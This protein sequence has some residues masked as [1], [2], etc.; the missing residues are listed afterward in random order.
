MARRRSLTMDGEP[1]GFDAG[2]GM[3]DDG[4]GGEGEGGGNFGFGLDAGLTDE[5]SRDSSGRDPMTRQSVVEGSTDRPRDIFGTRLP[6][7]LTPDPAP[8][9]DGGGGG[10]AGA[11]DINEILGM[12]PQGVE[13]G[14][15]QDTMSAPLQSS[16]P[17]GQSVSMQQMPPS[18]AAGGIGADE[19]QGQAS[20]PVSY[21]G[22]GNSPG[23][24]G[25]AGGLFGGGIGM[26]GGPSGQVSPT[27]QMLELARR[28]IGT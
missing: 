13:A 10:D 2:D 8:V 15:P 17:Q 25:R 5:V 23:L 28:L 14:G 18:M 27:E 12:L 1:Q 22:G 26:P 11:P 19:Q 3:F 24:V 7:T 16:S 21:F 9:S 6:R 20:S 4:G